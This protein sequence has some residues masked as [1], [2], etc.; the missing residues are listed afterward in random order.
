MF[1]R[2]EKTKK[3]YTIADAVKAAEAILSSKRI[4]QLNMTSIAKR[5]RGEAITL[6]EV[7][8]LADALVSDT[9]FYA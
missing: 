5:D 8:V 2:T 7:N 1:T 6:A 4:S 9:L 3:T